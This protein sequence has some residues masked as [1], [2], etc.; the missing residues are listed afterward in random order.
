MSAPPLLKPEVGGPISDLQFCHIGTAI[1]RQEFESLN[2]KYRLVVAKEYP[3]M[4]GGL[5]QVDWKLT[6]I[7][8]RANNQTITNKVIIAMSLFLSMKA[9]AY[10]NFVQETRRLISYS[11][12]G[13][14]C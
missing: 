9:S 11:P 5:Y 8:C 14:C 6:R 7:C 4:A 2:I 1:T 12:Q 13:V 10:S 3:R